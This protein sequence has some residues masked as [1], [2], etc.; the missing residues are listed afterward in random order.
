[1]L[2]PGCWAPTLGS[3][4][5]PA[6]TAL[7]PKESLFPTSPHHRAAAPWSGG[8]LICPSPAGEPGSGSA[9]VGATE[10][11]GRGHPPAPRRVLQAPTEGLALGCPHRPL[12]TQVFC[13]S[14][15]GGAAV[16]KPAGFWIEEEKKI[17]KRF[18]F[19]FFLFSVVDSTSKLPESSSSPPSA[20]D[21]RA[22]PSRP[23][24]PA[25][26]QGRCALTCLPLRPPG[27]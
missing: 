19:F 22:E 7:R 26:R 18:F 5:L 13:V 23:A 27:R 1:M 25:P 12:P 9:P 6:A 14:S 20:S 2:C 10:P 21:G 11:S 24:R 15:P 3:G 4:L 8:P 16:P 17:I